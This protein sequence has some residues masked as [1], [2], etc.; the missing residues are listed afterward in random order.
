MSAAYLTMSHR[1]LG[2]SEVMHRLLERRLAVAVEPQNLD[3]RG[4]LVGEDE[5]RA[6]LRILTQVLLSGQ[7]ETIERA[8]HV[9]RLLAYEDADRGGD[10]AAPRSAANTRAKVSTS[11]PAGTRTV[12]PARVT[13]MDAGAAATSDG[14]ASSMNEGS[15]RGGAVLSSDEFSSSFRRLVHIR[16][17]GSL[18]PCCRAYVA[19]GSPLARRSAMMARRSSRV[20]GFCMP[21]T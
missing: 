12:A 5:E 9:L 4:P 10:H 6:A 13:S 8:P 7:R 11:A 18:S 14:R 19:R 1:E 2:R 17:V 3:S 16:R 21:R 15:M 20:R